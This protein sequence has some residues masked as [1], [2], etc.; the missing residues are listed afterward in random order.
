VTLKVIGA[1]FGRTGTLSLKLAIEA[2]GLGPCYHMV[3][4][5]T[6]PEHDAMWLALA[7][8]EARDWRPTL[9]DYASTVDWPITYFWKDLAAANPDAKIV[10]TLRDP[11]DA[12][13]RAT[14]FARMLEFE[15]LRA[16][17]GA[18]DPVRRRHMEMINT[19][20]VEK[21]FG[22]SLVKDHALAVFNAHNEDV[23]SSAPP[24]SCSSLS[25]AKAGRSSAPSCASPSPRPPIPR[26]TAPATLCPASPTSGDRRP[27]TQQ[28]LTGATQG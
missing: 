21:T 17:P 19:I 28:A 27:A 13:A 12:S 4:T 10:L 6:H 18:V 3:E 26:S 16:E 5:R 2:L 15:T 8:G 14:I 25:Q 20:V 1:G 7:R 9:E 11:E 24:D 22:G 23:R